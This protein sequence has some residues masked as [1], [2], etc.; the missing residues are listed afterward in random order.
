MADR[1][2]STLQAA[3]FSGDALRKA[4]AIVMR[5]SGGNPT[6][7]N[8]DRSTGDDSRGL[9]QI[10]MLGDMG[11]QRDAWFRRTVE[12]YT[13]PQSLF[14]PVVN[15]RAAY[16]LSK[17]GTDFYHWDIDKNGYDGGSHAAAFQKWYSKYPGDDAAGDPVYTGNG[18]GQTLA[19][20]TPRDKL[21]KGELS[22]DFGQSYGVGLIMAH[23]ELMVLAYKSQGWTNARI[24]KRTGKIIKGKNT[25]IEWDAETTAAA[26]QQTKWYNARTGNQREAENAERM[27]PTS[28][29]SRIQN[30]VANIEQTATQ[31]GADLTGVDVRSFARQMLRDN[32]NYVSGS[33]D[34]QVPER[35]LNAFLKPYIK[36]GP[37]GN[38]RGQA[39][40]NA[41]TLRKNA[42][43]YGVRF[44]DD[45]YARAVQQIQA[46]EITQADLDNEIVTASRSRYQGLAGL[47][48]PT[49][50]L[51]DIAD[52]YLQMK[53]D[54]MEVPLETLTLEDPDIQAALQVRDPN[55]G[56][57][58]PQSLYE[59]KMALRQKP[60]WAG[61]TQGRQ[62]MNDG[63]MKMLKDFGFI[64]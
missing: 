31:V 63:A 57:V 52:P 60:A 6:A 29:N 42:D 16:V 25:G 55:T 47:I 38:F 56:N 11:K 18:S 12:G 50:S 15:A 59:F 14:D 49:R 8:P 13:G 4:W 17:H 51:A 58:M 23:P 1:V 19:T 30:L 9:F 28:F 7:Y 5:E 33:A 34:A 32:W 36:A 44:S 43:A 2:I 27:D 48:S 62:E 21:S 37:D 61:T 39:A 46:G 3:G 26:I 54:V 35:L 40:T 22:R 45:W 64:E 10:N 41:A 53:A 20:G 24:D